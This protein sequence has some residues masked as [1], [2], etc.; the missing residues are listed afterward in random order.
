MTTTITRRNFIS[1]LFGGF[2]WLSAGCSRKL[3][4]QTTGSTKGLVRLV[5]Y[6]DVHA[7]KEWETPIAMARAAKA[8]NAQNPDLVITGGDHITEGFE[9]SAH[10]VEH[11]WDAYMK[12]HRAIAADIYP[13]I[14]NH[15]LVA[16]VPDDGTNP[17]KDP[18]VIYRARMGLDQTYYSFDAAGYHF[19][20]LDSIEVTGDQYGYKGMIR[21]EQLEWLKEDL[22]KVWPNRPI[23]LSTHVPILSSFHAATMGPTFIPKRNRVMV[24]NLDILKLVAE[25]NVILV[26]QGH[27]H[28][29]EL[30]KWRDTT[31]IVGGAISAKWWRGP[32]HG[33][34]EGFSVITLDDGQVEWK[35]VDYGWDAKRP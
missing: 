22:S 9:S 28:A 32:W 29:K 18:R 27:L 7:R 35:Y 13:T 15:D 4:W 14:G 8:I 2:A 6:T 33:T 11:R 3:V 16:A 34:E 10:R 25:H 30:I 23:I 26:L 1:A 19:V 20:I 17:S 5:F 24:N 21:P 12:M 31:F